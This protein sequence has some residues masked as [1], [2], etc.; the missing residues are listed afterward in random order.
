LHTAE[1][2]ESV[3]LAFPKPTRVRASVNRMIRF[4]DGDKKYAP[5]NSW[6]AYA[7]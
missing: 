2:E 7:R 6:R 1:V 3:R 5:I 4:P